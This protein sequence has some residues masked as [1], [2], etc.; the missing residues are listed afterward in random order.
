MRRRAAALQQGRPADRR[1]R[2]PR[3][4]G[5]PRRGRRL[6]G[7]AL[8]ADQAMPAEARA[9]PWPSRSRSSAAGSTCWAPRS[10]IIRQ[11]GA[12]RIV[13]EA[14]G[15]SDP[16]E[17]EGRDRPDRQADLP[18]G[19]RERVAGEDAAGQRA[20]GRRGAAGRGAQ[21]RPSIVVKRRVSV[22][23][24]HADPRPAGV[25]P[26]QTRRMV[27]FRLNGQGAQRFG[28]VT[29]ENVGNRFA[30]ILDNKVIS[31]PVIES[32]IIGGQGQITG[33]FTVESANELAL[34]LQLRRAAGAAE[35]RSSSARSAPSWA[36]TR[37]APA[38]LAGVIGAGADRRLHHPG[39]RRLFGVLRGDRPDRQHADDV[40]RDVDDPGD[41][42][43]AGHR[44]PDPDHGHGG[45]RQRA[46]L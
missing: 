22:A 29:T 17:A 21:G 35:G 46:D 34:L 2:R 39:L 45:R 9:T 7:I 10:P 28:Q 27:A 3:G 41:A 15:E 43:A 1:A 32:P 37:C 31:A 23:G 13:I 42:D 38:R 11:Q 25:R 24:E 33:N 26:E 18:D 8:H 14:P 16:R 12:D 6:P 20:A 4:G 44:R 40:R 36:P 19:R 5:H 30:I